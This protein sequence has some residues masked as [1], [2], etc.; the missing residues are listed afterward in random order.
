MD[1]RKRSLFSSALLTT[2]GVATIFSSQ[3]HAK[4]LEE[5][6]VTAQKRTESVQDIPLT[7]AV[8]DGETLQEF[9]INNAT[10]LANN[11]PGLTL[12]PAPQGLSAPNIRGLGTG[13][14]AEN[15]E[16]S[17]GLFIDGVWTGKVRNLQTALHDVER[18]EVI[19]G[20]QTSQL[21]KNTSLGAIMLHSKRPENENGGFV[22]G[23]YD[24]ELETNTLSGVGN[25]GTEFGNYRVSYKRVGEGEGYVENTRLGGTEP[26]LEQQSLRLSGLWDPSDRLSIF[27]TYTYD[28]RDSPGY[29]FQVSA[30]PFGWYSA[31]TGDNDVSLDDQRKSS[32][33]YG[34]NGRDFDEQSGHWAVAEVSYSVSDLT[35]LVSVTGYNEYENERYYDADFSNADW[36][37]EYK[38]SDFEQFSQ[39]FRINSSAFDGKVNYL[40]GLYYVQH[41]FKSFEETHFAQNLDYFPLGNG[42]FAST[43]PARGY[44]NYE[45]DVD[46]WSFFTNTAIELSE[47]WLLTVGLRYSDESQNL[48][49]ERV[50]TQDDS[51]IFVGNPNT[52]P[53]AF[54]TPSTFISTVLSPPFAETE[55]EQSKDNID[56]SINL[57]Y[58]FGETGNV[59]AS[60]ATGSKSG[61]FTTS[62]SSPADAEFDTEKAETAE[63]GFKTELLNGSM[64]MNAALFRTEIEDFQSVTFVGTGFLTSTIP[65]ESK[66]VEFESMWAATEK[67]TISGSATYADAKNTDTNTTPAGAP[68]W[69]AAVSL[70]HVEPISQKYTLQ[71]NISANYQH[72]RFV[73]G[74]ETFEAPSI[75]LVD[76][77]VALLP[78]SEKWEV[79][80][81]VR[82]LFN[83]QEM[84]FGFA[85]PFYGAV[86]G[87]EIASENSPRTVSLQARWN[88]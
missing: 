40:A 72:E 16:Q 27:L 13:V 35:T 65:V 8:V 47:R 53:A 39:E 59:Y 24:F 54:Q 14:G 69:T 5:V 57:Q 28:D 22:Q 78:T 56:G 29:A 55:L 45:Q 26:K 81:M 43:G 25:W 33:T 63:V 4:E 52:D 15:I 19:K 9:S 80:L 79:A 76:T 67:L 84:N 64:R 18:V 41:N 71:S 46:S 3:I 42:A 1:S 49:W 31:I 77:R 17:V 32:N 75:T 50:Y 21:G 68:R 7:V 62:A 60:W 36:L 87:T 44:S 38:D 20:T 11:V 2:A 37:E 83:E 74:G 85:L 6:L 86:Y 73:Q 66:G 51:A 82:N 58:Q 12:S 34:N 30:D 10:D 61:G 23:E 88:F 48:V 70:S